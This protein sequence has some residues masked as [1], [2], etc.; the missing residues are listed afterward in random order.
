MVWAAPY[1]LPASVRPC[2]CSGR[3]HWTEVGD[4][5]AQQGHSGGLDSARWAGRAGLTGRSGGPSLPHNAIVLQTRGKQDDK[6][7]GWVVPTPSPDSQVPT[8]SPHGQVATPSLHGQAARAWRAC[9]RA[10]RRPPAPRAWDPALPLPIG[11]QRALPAASE[12]C[13]PPSFEN[14]RPCFQTMFIT[15]RKPPACNDNASLAVGGG[16]AGRSRGLVGA[17][18]PCRVWPV[19]ARLFPD[20]P[21]VAP[22]EAAVLPHPPLRGVPGGG[23]ARWLRALAPSRACPARVPASPPAAFGSRRRVCRTGLCDA[24]V[25]GPESQRLLLRQWTKLGF[26]CKK[27]RGRGGP[28]VM[29]FGPSLFRVALDER[30]QPVDSVQGG[31]RSSF[32]RGKQ[33]TV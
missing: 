16:G 24:A 31:S 27:A 6:S 22:A 10:P 11:A 33:S 30:I 23:R 26:G 9:P 8:P 14:Q 4:V 13:G 15:T 17:E 5:S 20:G 3:A 2:R 32:L 18:A 19:E 1:P 29:D 28:G 21:K 25:H 7:A 12:L